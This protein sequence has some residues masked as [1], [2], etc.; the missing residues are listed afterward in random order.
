MRRFALLAGFL[1]ALDGTLA[2]VAGFLSTLSSNLLYQGTAMILAGSVALYAAI[3]L[4]FRLS[5]P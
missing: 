5:K 4:V 3:L 2:V 1:I